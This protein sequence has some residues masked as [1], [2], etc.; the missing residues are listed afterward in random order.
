MNALDQIFLSAAE[1]LKESVRQD[2][3]LDTAQVKVI[4][5]EEIRRAA[6]ESWGQIGERIRSNS[7]LFLE[8]CLGDNDIIIPAGDGF[9]IVFADEPDRDPTRE[10]DQVRDALNGFFLGEQATAG[11]SAQVEHKAI[12]AGAM[13]ALLSSQ[14]AAPKPDKPVHHTIMLP[15]W[16]LAQG[17]IT[18]YWLA[19]TLAGAE[20]CGYDPAWRATGQHKAEDFLDLDLEILRRAIA[21][22]ER[23]IAT[24]RPSL[25]GYA[26]HSTTMASRSSR[27]TYLRHLQAIAQ[28]LRRYFVA[29]IAEI[30]P[31]TPNVVIAEWVHQLRP[32]SLRVNLE[33]HE[34]ERVI[35]GLEGTGAFSV[36]CVLTRTGNIGRYSQLIQRWQ[37][38]IRRQ[39]LKFR[40]DNIVDRD[41]LK[42]AVENGVDLLSSARIWTPVK[43]AEGVRPYSRAQFDQAL[44]A[45]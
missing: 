9:L 14:P 28:N 31:G 3:S 45:L 11:L 29:R 36:S 12:N 38:Q 23:C 34:S 18:G 7:M 15:V 2:R 21:A 4:G 24:S 1:K 30:A 6:G 37:P 32:I 41:L 33:L 40:L 17:A 8:G 43:E 13:A 44:A 26:V 22:A 42:L 39:G 35:T 27:Q 25:I 19:P 10:I 20:A 5:L 16:N